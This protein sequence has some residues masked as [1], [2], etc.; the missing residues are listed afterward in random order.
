MIDWSEFKVGRIGFDGGS[1]LSA[2]FRRS[3]M[4]R[5]ATVRNEFITTYLEALDPRFDRQHR[6]LPWHATHWAYAPTPTHHRPG[7]CRPPFHTAADT[8]ATA[9]GG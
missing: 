7:Q 4:V 5:F 2:V 1:Y 3:D 6:L 8:Q 9:R